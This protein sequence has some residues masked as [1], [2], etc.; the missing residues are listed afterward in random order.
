MRKAFSSSVFAV[1]D[2]T[3][4][5]ILHKRLGLW[6]PVGGELEVRIE[7]KEHD[8]THL[9][10]ETPLECAKRELWEETKLEAWY[11]PI[12]GFQS[13]APGFLGYGEHPA[14]DKGLHMNFNFLGFAKW[15]NVIGDDSFSQHHWFRFEEAA[16]LEGTTQSVKQYVAMIAGLVKTQPILARLALAQM[17]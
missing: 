7:L 12:T 1:S 5:L 3:V 15:D 16:N 14:G 13:E 11:V 9:H 2:E 10:F 8:T 17:K 4:L 6:L